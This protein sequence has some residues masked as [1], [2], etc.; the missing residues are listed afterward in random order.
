MNWT[1]FLVLKWDMQKDTDVDQSVKSQINVATLCS[2]RKPSSLVLGI[3]EL[4]FIPPVVCFYV[5]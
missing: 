5:L 1:Q 4:H 3:W 2:K